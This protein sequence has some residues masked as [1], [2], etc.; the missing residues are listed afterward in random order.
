MTMANITR[1]NPVDDLFNDLTQGFF[2][3]PLSRLADPV[4]GMRD[5]KLDVDED[6]KSYT[7]R[8]EIPG[9]KKEDIHVDVEGSHVSLRAEVKSEREEKE[10][11]R[12]VYSER[13]YGMVSRGFDLP[14][15][16]DAGGTKA[17]YRDGV[18]KLTLPKKAGAQT[19]RITVA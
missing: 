3:R 4:A 19:R 2:V 10:G 18:L 15:E 12:L 7:V 17:E 6:D 11:K 5:V 8:A 13:S 9:V 1:Y 16:V 14:H